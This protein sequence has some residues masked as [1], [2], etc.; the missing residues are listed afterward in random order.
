MLQ[1]FGPYPAVSALLNDLVHEQV[2]GRETSKLD[3]FRGVY[4]LVHDGI[5]VLEDLELTA[6]EQGVDRLRAVVDGDVRDLR[7]EVLVGDALGV[8]PALL[9]DGSL[10]GH[11]RPL[12]P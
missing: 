5:A 11:R 12:F 3:R 10:G 4:Q 8:Q 9:E 6:G 1:L 7:R 2:L